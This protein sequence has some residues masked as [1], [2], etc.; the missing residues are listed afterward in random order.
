MAVA[1]RKKVEVALAVVVKYFSLLS[2]DL[3]FAKTGHG[4]HFPIY[5][6]IFFLLVVIYVPFCVFCALFVCKLIVPPPG[7]NPISV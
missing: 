6:P 7:V 4:P 2:C 5:F 1:V 3:V